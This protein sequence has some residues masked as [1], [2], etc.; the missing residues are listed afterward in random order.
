MLTI[1]LKVL[2]IMPEFLTVSTKHVVV[3]LE[4]MTVRPGILCV[5]R[6]V[7]VL[8][9]Q[10]TRISTMIRLIVRHLAPRVSW[11]RGSF[12]KFRLGEDGLG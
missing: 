1:G 6:E 3:L 5:A 2:S 12:A 11:F 10:L 9:T 4:I 7:A 8:I